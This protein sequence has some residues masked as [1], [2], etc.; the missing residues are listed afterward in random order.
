MLVQAPGCSGLPPQ[1]APIMIAER[2]GLFFS[3]HADADS[4]FH[5]ASSVLWCFQADM[6]VCADMRGTL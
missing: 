1:E 2:C 6:E 5:C 4:T 3:F